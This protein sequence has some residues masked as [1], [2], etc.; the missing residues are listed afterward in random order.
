MPTKP[1]KLKAQ[2]DRCMIHNQSRNN[3]FGGIIAFGVFL[4]SIWLGS[5]KK[6]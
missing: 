6:H 1:E 3:R 5:K 4:A 2:S